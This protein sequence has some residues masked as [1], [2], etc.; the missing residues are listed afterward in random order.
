M[1]KKTTEEAKKEEP[2][3]TKTELLRTAFDEKPEWTEAE[4]LERTGYDK[5]NLRTAMAILRDGDRTK[6][7]VYIAKE[8]GIFKL[9][10]LADA[11]PKRERK[12]K[13]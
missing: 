9:G 5:G 4:L 1:A 12:A 2:R 6:D 10:D 13:E 3:V 11:P 7:P 8:G